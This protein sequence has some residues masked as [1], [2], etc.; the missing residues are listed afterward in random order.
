MAVLVRI[1]PA[2][3]L[4][5][6]TASVVGAQA[7]PA[8]PA[9]AQP[10]CE[11]TQVSAA[12][13]KANFSLQQALKDQQAKNAANAT[14]NLQATV[15][16]L[17]APSK[18]EELG[19][20]YMLGSALALWLNQPG[21]GVTPKRS[22]V[23]F[24]SN[25][26][27]TIDLPT[28]IDSLFKIV[29][30]SKPGCSY[31]TAY[32][33]GGQQAY[34]DMVNNAIA[35]LNADKLDSAQYYAT[36]A[37][38][39]YSESPYGSMVLGN[40]AN[41]RNNNDEAVKQWQLAAKAA[42]GDTVYRDVQRQVLGNIAAV[43]MTT[44]REEKTAPAARAEAAKKAAEVYNELLAV[45]GTTGAA[46]AGARQNLQQ[47]LLLTGD[48]TAVTKSYSDMLANPSAYSSQ[49]LLTSAVAAVR[50]NKNADA[51]KLFDA[52][53]VANPYS[54]DALFNLA[55]THLNLGANDKVPPLVTRLVAVDPGNPEN[56]LLAARAYV[57]IAKTRKGTAATQ[58]VNDTTVSWFN[59]GQKLPVEVTFSEFSPSEK[60][61][62]IAG[63]VLDRRDKA[64]DAERGGT[65]STT[66]RAAARAAA[67]KKPA[68][69]AS[70]FA[71]KAVT[72]KF[73][74]LDKAGAV[75]GTQSVTTEA[76]Q[77]GKSAAFKVTIP[78]ANAIAFR[79]TIAD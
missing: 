52:V 8:Q 26:E 31:Y 76:L 61:L 40:I 64:A 24:T 6:T 16:A 7:T 57:D 56:Y 73:E 39:L 4:L 72:L 50:A 9:Q 43:Y 63:H 58:A 51:A 11:A 14:K 20:A 2:A 60:Q 74:A 36:I 66:T 30:A 54:R 69:A 78:A 35:A 71:P 46:A 49:D 48:T 33:R 1:L 47:A 70:S 53:L 25:P 12:S 38:R 77:P 44:A 62:D 45:P 55:V 28:T 41:K 65:T 17:E 21:V 34:L 5:V 10:V 22:A 75:L 32:W 68:A 3:A 27:A 37:N 13:V 42:A 67:A 23:G 79:Y 18:G 29:E 19:R 15:K 59:R